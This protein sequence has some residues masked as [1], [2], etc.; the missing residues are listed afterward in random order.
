MKNGQQ[1]AA[2]GPSRNGTTVG[3][4]RLRD[5]QREHRSKAGDQTSEADETLRESERRYRTLFDLFPMAV[6]SCNASGVILKFNRR[7]AEMWGREPVLGETGD[8]FCGSFKLFRPD[9][10]FIAREQCP[11]ADVLRGTIPEVHD[12]EVLVER[13]DGSRI[14][15]LVN[16]RPVKNE[17]REVAGAINC[18]YDITER[19]RAEEAQHRLA[20]VTASNEKLEQE[21]VRRQ[22]VQEQLRHLSHQILHAQ[23]EERKRISRELHD[24]IAQMLVNINVHLTSLICDTTGNC[25]ALPSKI[26]RT[27]RLVDKSLGVVHDF[28]R[29]LRPIA[30][31]DLGLVAALRAFMQEFKERT[32]VHIR[33]TTFTSGRIKQL[34]NDKSTVLYRVAQEALTNVARHAKATLVEVNFEKLPDAICLKIKDNGKSFQAQRVL[35]SKHNSRLGLLGMR[36]RL[37]MVGGSLS[38]ESAR[39]SGTLIQAQ[40]PLTKRRE[41]GEREVCQS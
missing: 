7:A 15:A 40:I 33:F 21:I 12:A 5:P 8:R 19:K 24:E 35:Q 9:G 28:A 23:E 11:M 20:V 31:D 13:P 1:R 4:G 22:A 14:Y 16:I 29:Q 36:E 26:K 37:E 10:R 6:Y 30:L 18:F 32:G 41:K 38:I 2:L 17:R 34:N 27:Q 3:A 25:K 39:G